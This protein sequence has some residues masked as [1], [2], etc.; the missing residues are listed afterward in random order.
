MHEIKAK[1]MLADGIVRLDVECPK[2][3]RKRKAGQFV[4]VRAAEG[5]ERIPLTICD[6]DAE[7]GTIALIIQAVGSSSKRLCDL[8]EGESISDI[9][10][11]LGLP[12]R[13]D[14]VDGLCVCVG[15][16]LGTAPLYP[17]AQALH[18][19]GVELVSILGARSSE[20][21][22]LRD[23]FEA[24]SDQ[25]LI[26]T[27]DGS[28][29][30]KG[31]VSE[32]LAQVIEERETAACVAIGPVLMMK[33]C[34]EVTRPSGIPTIVSLNPI[35]VDGTGMC[36]GCRVSVGGDTKFACVDGP[37]FDGH[38]VD[39]DGLAQRLRTYQV[40]SKHECRLPREQLPH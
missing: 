11:P 33:A 32:V 13:L 29:G 8:D 24:I 6:A 16:G 38:E 18:E 3:A 36:G 15:G 34:A 23:E 25:L 40:A 9:A 27:D 31:F 17:I 39:F 22:I 2:I 28:E 7:A 37:E 20:L 1:S 10:G 5:A 14:E 4:I 21:I 35:M 26:A 19:Q 12:T 30:H